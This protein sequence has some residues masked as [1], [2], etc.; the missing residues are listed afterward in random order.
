MHMLL[1]KQMVI[2]NNDQYSGCI[3][4]RKVNA[5]FC[6]ETVNDILYNILTIHVPQ[7]P[8]TPQESVCP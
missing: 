6:A 4:C 8:K 2:N 7:I 1:K 5:N 3:G